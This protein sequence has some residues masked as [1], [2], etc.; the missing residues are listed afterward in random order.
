M[1]EHAHHGHFRLAATPP[2]LRHRR[3]RGAPDLLARL[4]GKGSRRDT[5]MIPRTHV[6]RLISNRR[7]YPSGRPLACSPVWMVAG[8]L[9]LHL[10]HPMMRAGYVSDS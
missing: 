6:R 5:P 2:N 10:S 9:I 4:F 3:H 1:L 8:I 7:L